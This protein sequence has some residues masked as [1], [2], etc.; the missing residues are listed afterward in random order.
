MQP[1]RRRCPWYTDVCR[2]AAGPAP[3]YDR[4]QGS[5]LIFA[6]PGAWQ[7]AAPARNAG[8]R[9]VTVLPPDESPAAIRWPPVANWIGDADLEGAE[10]VAL[11][12][13]LIAAGAQLVILRVPRLPERSLV[14]RRTG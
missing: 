1:D 3:P 14:A 12:R 8:R 9:A 11:A 6:G 13:E 4:W 7:A 5:A 2:L 10:A